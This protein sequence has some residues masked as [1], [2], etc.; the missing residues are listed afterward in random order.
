MS[1][2]NRYEH[3]LLF[4]FFSETTTIVE[5]TL[6]LDRTCIPSTVY[7]KSR[8]FRHFK[9]NKQNVL[10]ILAKLNRMR[11]AEKLDVFKK[12]AYL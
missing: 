3:F 4:L 7:Y 11:G 5:I 6:Y 8:K 1:K 2:N 9:T 12:N 10:R